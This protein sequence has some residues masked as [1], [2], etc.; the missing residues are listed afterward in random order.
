MTTISGWPQA[1][2]SFAL[3]GLLASCTSIQGQR[4]APDGPRS[5]TN[6]SSSSSSTSSAAQPQQAETAEQPSA[7]PRRHS[8]S[9][10]IARAE[11][12]PA[13]SQFL[14]QASQLS[15]QGDFQ[16]ALALL[17]RA[18][19]IS[20]AAGEVYL[21]M[22]QVHMNMGD[23]EKA[24]QLCYKAESLSGNDSGFRD[25]VKRVLNQLGSA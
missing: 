13:A 24:R 10:Q 19:R 5:Q 1:V 23:E 2:A 20:P 15:G 7:A 3:A 6:S 4:E 22:A 8:P 12:L 18:R 25:S 17:E 14:Q 9:V 16:R 11:P 21:A